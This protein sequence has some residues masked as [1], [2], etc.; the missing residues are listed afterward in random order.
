[1]GTKPH[2]FKCCD[3][4]LEQNGIISSASIY[5]SNKFAAAFGKA[6]LPV[7]TF[8]PYAIHRTLVPS[9]HLQCLSD[10]A[11]GT[12]LRRDDHQDDLGGPNDLAQDCSG[13][14]GSLSSKLTAAPGG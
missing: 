5:R 14:P 3:S 7:L 9:S 11:G 1:M 12:C 13:I 2:S 10:V 8:D 4:L 6:L